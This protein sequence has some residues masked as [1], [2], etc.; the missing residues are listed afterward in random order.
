MK[1]KNGKG[2]TLQIALIPRSAKF[3]TDPFLWRLSSAVIEESGPFSEFFGYQRA[4]VLLSGR[5]L[6]IQLNSGEKQQIT[7][8]SVFSF[9]GDEKAMGFL[10]DGP[11]VDLNLIWNDNKI[12]CQFKPVTAV[13]LDSKNGI[14]FIV[15]AKTQTVIFYFVKPGAQINESGERISFSRGDT[16][17]LERNDQS[18]N[19]IN[20]KV[21]FENLS[22]AEPSSILLYSIELSRRD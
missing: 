17:I 13:E 19:P 6:S 4:I 11:V 10:Q 2:E 7:Q 8:N 21:N 22:D 15:A 9:S 12:G 20:V 18:G 14:T 16:S 1:W 5:G 3:P